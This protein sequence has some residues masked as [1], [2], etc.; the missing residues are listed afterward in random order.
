M[1]AVYFLVENLSNPPVL[2][3]LVRIQRLVPFSR[4]LVYDEGLNIR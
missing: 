3:E 1:D 4:S 2:E